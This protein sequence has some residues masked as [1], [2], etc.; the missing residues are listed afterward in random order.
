MGSSQVALVVKEK[1]KKKTFLPMQETEE[2]Q[3]QPLG[4]EDPLKEG[5]EIH[6]SILA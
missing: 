3:V 1:K 2:M 5:M 6:S 4:Q